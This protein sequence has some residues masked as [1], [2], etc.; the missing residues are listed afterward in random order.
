MMSMPVDRLLSEFESLGED[1]EFGLVQRHV[2]AEPLGLLR[3]AGFAVPWETRLDFAID[4]IGRG[5]EGLADPG[6]VHIETE[7]PPGERREFMV[8]ESRYH[9]RYHTFL[10]QGEADREALRIQQEKVLR[11]LHEK[12]LADLEA[13]TKIWV[14]KSQTDCSTSDMVRLLEVLRRTGPNVLLWASYANATHPAGTIEQLSNHLVRGYIT[15]RSNIFEFN[16]EP[17]VSICHRAYEVLR[18]QRIPALI[19]TGGLV[20]PMRIAQ[21]AVRSEY[22][23]RMVEFRPSGAISISSKLAAADKPRMFRS[24]S[25]TAAIRKH[26]IDDVVLDGGTMSLTKDGRLIE[27]T[28]S[29]QQPTIGDQAVDTIPIDGFT[30]DKVIVACNPMWENYFH[31]MTQCLPAIDW[32][33]GTGNADELCLAL[34]HLRPWQEETLSLLFYDKLRRS[35]IEPNHRY[36]ISHAIFSDFLQGGTPF[37]VSGAV[38]YT[39]KRLS[40]AVRMAPTGHEL[41][42]VKGADQ[43]YGNLENEDEL[44][45]ALGG[46]GFHVVDL[47]ELTVG[48][49]IN[50]FRSAKLVLTPHGTAMTNVA[51]CLPGTVVWELFPSHYINACYN[52]LAQ[53]AGLE[54]WADLVESD[55]S[56]SS[57]K[58]RV[59]LGL[60]MDRFHA[61]AIRDRP[62]FLL[63]RHA[64]VRQSDRDQRWANAQSLDEVLSQFESLGEDCEFGLMQKATGVDHLALLRFASFYFPHEERLS[65]LI[66]ALD[67]HFESL[68]EPG[69]VEVRLEGE[70]GQRK[71]FLGFESKYH[72]LYHTNVHDGDIEPKRLITQ[73][74]TVLGFLRRKLLSDLQLGEK[75]WVWKTRVE[76]SA[77][78][79][80]RLHDALRRHGPNHLLWVSHE[81]EIH[82][83]GDVEIVREGLWHGYVSACPDPLRYVAAPWYE[84]CRKAHRL[85]QTAR[86]ISLVAESGAGSGTTGSP[87][88]RHL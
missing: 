61:M 80:I 19:P 59:D 9:L 12:F 15:C 70:P 39:L 74:E 13:G 85:C 72:L 10:Y 21:A 16:P 43:Y 20:T 44:V 25:R 3:F 53:G 62:P 55:E 2:G 36:Q 48:D 34:P 29:W 27:E 35:L 23:E 79:M 83:G 88:A 56:S 64:H 67:R 11:F 87:V 14:W 86:T 38:I 49:R 82:P 6:T 40:N 42:Y 37:T 32:A 73:Q 24:Q 57:R 5:L 28:A 22:V 77:D 4:A 71:E 54:Y 41:V 65:R 68:G 1:C 8:S 26:L 51:F 84:V 69:T 17:W 47:T 63:A 45:S 66:D 7:G 52:R 58:W 46:M 76:R 33:V 75:I 30:D 81:T 60:I 31:W 18:Q 78:E 50:L